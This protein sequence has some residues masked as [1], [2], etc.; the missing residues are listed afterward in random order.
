MAHKRA[1]NEDTLY[2]RENRNRWCAQVSLDGRR[3]TLYGKTQREYHDWI[4]EMQAKIGSGLTFEGTQ[5]T[6]E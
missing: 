1:N 5:A 6:L 4:K 3:L 2:Y